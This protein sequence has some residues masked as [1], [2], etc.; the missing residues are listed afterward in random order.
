MALG[1]AV[2]DIPGLLQRS[3]YY[4][5]FIVTGDP[6]LMDLDESSDVTTPCLRGILRT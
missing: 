2:L 6:E 4:I 5:C 1:K 3:V